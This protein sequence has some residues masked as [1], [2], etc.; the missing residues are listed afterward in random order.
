MKKQQKIGKNEENEV[1]RKSPEKKLVSSNTNITTNTEELIK[2]FIKE[3]WRGFEAGKMQ[4]LKHN[5]LLQKLQLKSQKEMSK[6]G[7]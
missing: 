4:S 2:E 1:I 6:N 7:I 5:I 3:Y